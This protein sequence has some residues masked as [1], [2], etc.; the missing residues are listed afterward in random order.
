MART[1]WLRTFVCACQSGSISEAARLRNISQP[2]ATGHVRSLEAAAGT[3][4]FVR[5]RDGVVPTET[6]RRLYAEVVD[7]LDR[8]AGVLAGLDAG[9]LP[10][11]TSPLR[12]GSSPE[13]FAG[14]VA[15]HLGRVSARVDAVFGDDDEL[16]ACLARDDVDLVVTAAPVVRRWAVSEVVGAHRYALVASAGSPV[17]PVGRLD[18]LGGRLGDAPWVSY[19]DDLPR[20]RRFWKQHLGRP[21]DARVRLVAP[22]LRVVLSAV[23]AGLGASLLPTM[24]CAPALERG[25]VFEVF[26]VGDLI[27][28]RPLWASTRAAVADRPDIVVVLGELKH[29]AA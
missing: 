25:S 4:L 15:R 20:T 1:E 18:E 3:R 23:E 29:A 10:L 28:P 7:P 17:T 11:P 21:F 12:V 5:R 26:P 13:V 9:A 22:D 2:A 8:L 16:L 27:E 19:S 6:G 14:L 24:V